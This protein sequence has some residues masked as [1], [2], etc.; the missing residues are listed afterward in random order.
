MR[1][2]KL[3]LLLL[4][5]PLALMSQYR[6]LFSIEGNHSI[7]GVDNLGNSYIIGGNVLYQYN[8]EGTVQNNFSDFTKGNIS[9]VNV[10]NPL[11]IIVLWSDPGIVSVLD[12][13]LS[14]VGNSVSLFQLGV[15]EP[16]LACTSEG[17]GLWVY[18]ASSG[19]LNLF[20]PGGSLL[21]QSLDLRKLNQGNFVP[22]GMCLWSNHIL[23]YSDAGNVMLLDNAA[24]VVTHSKL[25][26][27]IVSGGDNGF[28]V[29]KE[30]GIQLH[31]LFN[32]RDVRVET[33]TA[34]I[35]KYYVNLPYFLVR[36]ETKISLYLLSAQ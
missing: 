9:H 27:G 14:P 35:K 24:T 32:R 2:L 22:D 11:K 15:A 13:T 1:T 6:E 3:I 30:T 16:I 17:D 28:S 12:N 8:S 23:L 7:V 36:Y 5:V 29:L 10:S 25:G 31:D 34:G 33:P 4:F 18:D 21:L 19:T 26:G 20:S